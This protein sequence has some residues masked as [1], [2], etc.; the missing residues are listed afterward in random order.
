M[1]TFGVP[2]KMSS[3]HKFGKEEP[4]G[5]KSNIIRTSVTS[6]QEHMLAFLPNNIRSKYTQQKGATVFATHPVYIRPLP[7]KG[8]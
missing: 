4:L 6:R 1:L 2:A 8:H 7:R 3:H 5:S